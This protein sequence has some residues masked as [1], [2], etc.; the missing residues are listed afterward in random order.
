MNLNDPQLHATLLR[1]A[2][3]IVAAGIAGAAGA[4]VLALQNNSGATAQFIAAAAATGF[5]TGV[6]LAAEKYLTWTEVPPAPPA[7]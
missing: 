1:F 5:I 3:T 7:P 6:L 2:K 4:V